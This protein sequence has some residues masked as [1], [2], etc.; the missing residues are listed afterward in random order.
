VISA[1]ATPQHMVHCL[2]LNAVSHLPA[3]LHCCTLLR[4]VLQ[5]WQWALLLVQLHAWCSR[6]HWSRRCALM[7]AIGIGCS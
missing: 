4:H 6:L 2:P 5:L 3:C 1:S 7:T